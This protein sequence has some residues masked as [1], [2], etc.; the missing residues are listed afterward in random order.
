MNR[1]T[2]SPNTTLETYEEYIALGK[3]LKFAYEQTVDNLLVISRTFGKTKEVSRA[4]EKV[5][6]ANHDLRSL[7]D[8]EV[9][10]LFPDR[11]T[12]HEFF[13]PLEARRLTR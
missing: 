12:G 1:K 4:A 8:S 13:G 5:V 11:F 7:L 6:V 3:S 2:W 10:S 9:A